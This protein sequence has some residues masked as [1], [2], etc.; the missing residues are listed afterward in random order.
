MV[1]GCEVGSCG[2][3]AIGRCSSCQRAFC[4]SHQGVVAS[5]VNYLNAGAFYV[6]LCKPCAVD[7]RKAVERRRQR[8]RDDK[9]AAHK[10]AAERVEATRARIREVAAVLTALAVAPTPRRRRTG[11]E[12][13]WH[14]PLTRFV[15]MGRRELHEEL[16]P[17]WPV[18]N[19]KWEW[20]F[21][22]ST[23]DV[24]EPAGV[25]SDAQIVHM[26]FQGIT[27]AKEHRD[28]IEDTYCLVLS[29]LEQHLP[30]G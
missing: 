6:D 21:A 24:S 18:G 17:A 12:F 1:A 27:L 9:A 26:A 8:E 16:T 29:R 14:W 4:V 3:G 30:P 2:V 20:T 5:S 23:T 7:Y 19:L 10:T 15:G 25:T 22:G 28:N 11:V 13:A